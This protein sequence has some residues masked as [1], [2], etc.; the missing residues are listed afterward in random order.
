[1]YSIFTH[2]WLIFMINADKYSIHGEFRFWSLKIIR[3][4]VKMKHLKST[5]LKTVKTLD[6]QDHYTSGEEDRVGIRWILFTE[7][8]CTYSWTKTAT[9]CILGGGFK[10]VY[11]HPYLGKISNL[12]NI[13]QMGWNHQPVFN[14]LYFVCLVVSVTT[15]IL[16]FLADL[17]CSTHLFSSH[18]A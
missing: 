13:F 10:Y 1:M 2:T 16:H 6:K 9:Q 18:Q 17:N 3:K 15:R 11:F 14:S 5:N 8:L 12:T 4:E 7:K